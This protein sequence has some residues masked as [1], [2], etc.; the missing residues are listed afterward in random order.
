MDIGADY[1]SSWHKGKAEERRAIRKEKASTKVKDTT[2]PT[3]TKE[4]KR[5]ISSYRSRESMSTKKSIQ[6]S[7]N[8][9][10]HERK[11]KIKRK[12][13][14]LQMWA[15]RPHQ[16]ELPSCSVQLWQR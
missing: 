5:R 2:A 12:G 3:T 16:K 11:R 13:H 6:R 7:I 14:M 4:R 10:Q 15:T 1:N 8:P 9:K